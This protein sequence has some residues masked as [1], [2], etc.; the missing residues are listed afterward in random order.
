MMQ[1]DSKVI[2]DPRLGRM[3]GSKYRDI[4]TGRFAPAPKL[5]PCPPHYWL[6][7]SEN[8]GHCKKCGAVQDF[9]KELEKASK[10]EFLYPPFVP[11]P[12]EY[13]Y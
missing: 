2:L 3:G 10:R 4:K 1:Q 13:E 12:K 9:G 7:N 6:I 8:V 5:L 11:E